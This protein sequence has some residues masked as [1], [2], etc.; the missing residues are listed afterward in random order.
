MPKSFENMA[1]VFEEVKDEKK[2]LDVQERWIRIFLISILFFLSLNEPTFI[3][4]PVRSRDIID[5]KLS[6]KVSDCIA[7][8]LQEHDTLNVMKHTIKWYEHMKMCFYKFSL[9]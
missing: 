1:M 4:L 2:E 3:W 6:L 7:P 9:Y 8:I 5:T